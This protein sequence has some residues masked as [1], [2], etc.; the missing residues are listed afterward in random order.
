MVKAK[1]YSYKR[2][3]IADGTYHYPQ[4][5]ENKLCRVGQEYFRS[6][7]ITGSNEG[8]EKE[9]KISHLSVYRDRTIPGMDTV[10]Q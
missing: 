9:P 3:Y 1:K 6:M 5:P 8:T 10:A 7:E 2:M 4:L